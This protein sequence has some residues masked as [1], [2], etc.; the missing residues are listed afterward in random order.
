MSDMSP[1]QRIDRVQQERPWLGIPVA[2]AK[3]FVEDKSTNMASMIAF[4]AFFSLFPLLLAFI[5]LL[6]SFVPA[7]TKASCGG[8]TSRRS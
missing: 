5:T 3:K 7:D 6:G 1:L 4:W 2:T 8:S